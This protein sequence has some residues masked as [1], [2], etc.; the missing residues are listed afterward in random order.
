MTSVAQIPAY[1][2]DDG[3]FTDAND[4]GK[5]THICITFDKN[6]SPPCHIY[7]NST[8]LNVTVLNG[9]AVDVCTNISLRLFN[10]NDGGWPMFGVGISE[11][12][13]YNRALTSN[14]VL[15]LYNQT[16]IP[17]ISPVTFTPWKFAWKWLPTQLIRPFIFTTP[18]QR[19]TGDCTPQTPMTEM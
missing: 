17:P 18:T 19:H 1:A 13:L 16:T 12:Q 3:T 15:T 7:K 9:P 11:V 8:N 4:T 6:A 2:T 5:W 14:E 10:R